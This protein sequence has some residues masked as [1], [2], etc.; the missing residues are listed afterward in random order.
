[1]KTSVYRINPER[2]VYVIEKI[3]P[4]FVTRIT[5]E[6]VKLRKGEQLPI[7]LYLDSPGGS[8]QYMNTLLSLLTSKNQD[9]EPCALTTVAL[10]FVASAAAYILINGDYAVAYPNA[11]IHCHGIRVPDNAVT[12]EK[13]RFFADTL[14]QE[15]YETALRMSK[16]VMSRLLFICANTNI[17]EEQD[18][19]LVAGF[20]DTLKSRVK[21]EIFKIVSSAKEQ[22]DQNKQLLE[23][24]GK[25]KSAKKMLNSLISY[26]IKKNKKNSNNKGWFLLKEGIST[27]KNY[28]DQINDMGEHTGYY[29]WLKKEYGDLLINGNEKNEYEKRKK[30]ETKEAADAYKDSCVSG[31]FFSFF[32]FVIY[33]CRNLQKGENELTAVEAYWLGLVDEVLGENLPCQRLLAETKSN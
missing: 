12:T 25:Q 5:P 24:L 6:I 23:I 26:E 1:M 8:V 21:P 13:A 15:N 29:E 10:S 3:T 30:T 20:V 28:C 9:N 11:T 19:D 2:A 18:K 31:K 33:L 22:L 16:R 7:T 4:S 32:Y 17:M 27:I 14:Q